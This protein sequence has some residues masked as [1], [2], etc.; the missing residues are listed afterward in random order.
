MNSSTRDDLLE[1]A[2]RC[3]LDY[4]EQR[5]IPDDFASRLSRSWTIAGNSVVVNILLYSG[6]GGEMGLAHDLKDPMPTPIIRITVEEN[7][8]EARLEELQS[9]PW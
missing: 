8:R 7:S 2:R 1:I 3:F 4:C 5:P 9:I 6:K